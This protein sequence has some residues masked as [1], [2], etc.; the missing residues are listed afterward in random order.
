MKTNRNQRGDTII[1]VLIC[2]A[3]V[4]FAVGVAYG[5]SG[6]SLQQAIRARERTEAL[7][8]AQAQVEYLKKL[9]KENPT[10]LNGMKAGNNCVAVVGLNVQSRPNGGNPDVLAS[11]AGAYNAACV[12]AGKYFF[13]TICLP[14]SGC[15]AA[16]D[17]TFE[18]SVRW[19]RLAGGQDK[20]SIVYRP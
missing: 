17:S 9:S 15:N 8:L 6:R 20:S 2:I 7:N 18:V 12:S 1:E 16:D 5:L 19:D 3:I 13:N 11:G 4:A 14:T 10:A